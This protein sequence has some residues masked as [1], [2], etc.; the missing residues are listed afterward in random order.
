MS[1]SLQYVLKVFMS[2]HLNWSLRAKLSNENVWH[3]AH[4][5]EAVIHSL[6]FILDVQMFALI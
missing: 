5:L 6:Q 2:L 4:S 1:D 3:H